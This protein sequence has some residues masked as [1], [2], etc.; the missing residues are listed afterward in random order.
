MPSNMGIAAGL[1]EEMLIDSESNTNFA[2]F[3][4]SKLA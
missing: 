2:E 3:D 4:L 1:Y